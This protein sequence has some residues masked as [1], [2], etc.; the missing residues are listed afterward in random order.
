MMNKC[1]KILVVGL[2]LCSFFF[3]DFLQNIIN[4]INEYAIS[5]AD[6]EKGPG[7][8]LDDPNP[9]GNTGLSLR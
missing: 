1:K 8:E 5:L 3:S 4:Y 7:F 6:G 2:M 9:D